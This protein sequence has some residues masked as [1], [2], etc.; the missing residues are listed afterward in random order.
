VRPRS[1]SRPRGSV[2]VL[3][4]LALAAAC[5]RRGSEGAPSPVASV[6]GSSAVDPPGSLV[7]AVR[8]HAVTVKRWPHL[9]HAWMMLLLTSKTL[10]AL[11][12]PPR[13]VSPPRE[14]YGAVP[15]PTPVAPGDTREGSLDDGGPFLQSGPLYR[16]YAID[17]EAGQRVVLDVRGGK[18]ITEP[19]CTL[20]VTV[21]VLR[22]GTTLAHDDDGGGFFDARLDFT[23]PERARYAV[24]VSTYGSGRRRGAYTLRVSS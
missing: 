8:T 17:L 10:E 6:S 15:A 11:G 22:D 20:D 24:R 4:T 16:D 3:A 18:S 5:S 1:C 2:F 14:P 12:F 19:C 9:E 21:D 23:A 13:P 7:D